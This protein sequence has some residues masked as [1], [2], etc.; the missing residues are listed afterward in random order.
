MKCRYPL[1]VLLACATL[2]ALADGPKRPKPK[3]DHEAARAAL[4]RGEI[5]PLSRILEIS[6]GIAPGNIIEIELEGTPLVYKIKVL[7][8]DGQVRKLKLDARDGSLIRKK[9]DN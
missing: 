7:A 5:L 4:S 3:D 2:P 6:A 8:D 9:D 1:L